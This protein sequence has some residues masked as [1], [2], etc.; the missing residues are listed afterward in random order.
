MEF[1]DH[2][3]RQSNAYVKYRPTYPQELY[4]Y[5]ASL[6]LNHELAWDCGTGNGQAALGL[7]D[8]YAQIYANDASENQIA[9]AVHHE[10]INYHLARVE[11]TALKDQSVDLITIGLA[12]HWFN[13]ELFY[14][15]VNRVLKPEG[16]I[17]AWTY[18]LPTISSKIDPIIRQ[19][20][21]DVVDDY[22]H[23]ENR[24]VDQGYATIPF[25]FQEI[26]PPKL[27]MSKNWSLDELLGLVG[28]WS[29]VQR[30]IQENK[31]D[32]VQL[33]EDELVS[34]WGNREEK[35]EMNWELILKI[36]KKAKL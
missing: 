7:T 12:L 4:S 14:A 3:S 21:D 13:L 32:P 36:G 24:L 26:N 30:Y 6:T 8:Y 19:F 35:K 11:E 15:E 33:L 17:A 25:P 5:L 18:R 27:E 31:K 10:Q 23:E 28:S 22:W 16:V 1:K 20:H 34:V 29:A 9:N 2:F